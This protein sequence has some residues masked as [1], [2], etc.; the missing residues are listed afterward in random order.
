MQEYL[1]IL[2]KRPYF[3]ATMFGV[4]QEY[5]RTMPKRLLLGVVRTGVM[6]LR[7]PSK[8]TMEDMHTLQS[9]SLSDIYRWA[10]KPGINFYFETKAEDVDDGVTPVYSFS[11]TEVRG[12][13]PQLK[14]TDAS[15]CYTQ[16]AP[17]KHTLM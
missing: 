7:P 2:T 12:L 11:T 13:L 4:K 1:N 10:Y 3:G 6:L 16:A 17:V 15:C 14:C 8:P 9:Y 5:T